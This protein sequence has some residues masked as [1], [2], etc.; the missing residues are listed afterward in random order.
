MP[1]EKAVRTYNI[2]A[3]E[4][5]VIKFACNSLNKEVIVYGILGNFISLFDVLWFEGKRQRNLN[6]CHSKIRET[7]RKARGT[8]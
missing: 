5:A 6:P 8:N 7:H 3:I 2:Y 1:I 4:S